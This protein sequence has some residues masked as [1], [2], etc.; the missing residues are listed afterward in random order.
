MVTGDDEERW[1]YKNYGGRLGASD[2]TRIR[3]TMEFLG[4]SVRNGVRYRYYRDEGGAILYD[5]EPE[6]GKPEWMIL[7]DKAARRRH[8]IYN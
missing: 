8:G 6:E 3:Q 4:M 7:A 2:Q 5:S 1:M